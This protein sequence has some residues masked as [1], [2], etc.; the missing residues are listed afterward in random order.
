MRRSPACWPNQQHVGY[1]SCAAV[2]LE[3]DI[4]N[5]LQIV[6]NTFRSQTQGL[7]HWTGIKHELLPGN[8]DDHEF[9]VRVAV[10]LE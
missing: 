7:L 8:A 1:D 2:K 3:P 5:Q 10:V 9:E 6:R 4:R